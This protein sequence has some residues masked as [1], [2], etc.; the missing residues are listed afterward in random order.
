MADSFSK[1]VNSYVWEDWSVEKLRMILGDNFGV[2]L[3]I[4]PY[5]THVV[6]TP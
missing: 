5:E 4:P 6:S 3:P 2:S 1:H